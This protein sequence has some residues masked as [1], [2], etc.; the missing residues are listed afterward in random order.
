MRSFIKHML[1]LLLTLTLFQ[2]KPIDTP[3]PNTEDNPVFQFDLEV[4]GSTKAFGTGKDGYRMFT[5]YSLDSLNV[6]SF[7]GELKSDICQECPSLKFTIRDKYLASSSGITAISESVQL[8]E[9]SY[10]LALPTFHTLVQFKVVQIDQKAPTMLFWDFGD[11]TDTSASNLLTVEHSYDI[12]SP[13][14]VATKSIASFP[15][16]S[17]T[18]KRDLELETRPFE[19]DYYYNF[20]GLTYDFYPLI[21]QHLNPL[22]PTKYTWDFGDGNTSSEKSLQ[23]TY[24]NKGNYKVCLIVENQ[25]TLAT[26]TF[27]RNIKV[28]TPDSAAVTHDYVMTLIESPEITKLSLGTVMLEYTNEIGEKYSSALNRQSAISVLNINEIK[29]FEEN[30]QGQKTILIKLIGGC[31]LINKNNEKIDLEIKPS[32]VAVAYPG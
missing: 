17:S 20:S 31:Q 11:G 15:T 22:N 24:A 18:L 25:K 32:T 9:T 10:R 6:Y 28:G 14:S 19:A 12:L 8:G 3:K 26:S 27:C 16:F 4:N 21:G 7:I 5:S 29:D 30:G 1:F 2:C 23:H 13:S